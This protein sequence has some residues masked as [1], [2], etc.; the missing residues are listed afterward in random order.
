MHGIE[1]FPNPLL[2]SCFVQYTTLCARHSMEEETSDPPLALRPRL[3][4]EVRNHS[5]GI[6]EEE[7][8]SPLASSFRPVLSLSLPPSLCGRCT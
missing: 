6:E 4:R 5:G 2:L 1:Y 7:E 3:G 8:V